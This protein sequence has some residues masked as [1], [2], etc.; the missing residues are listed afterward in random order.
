M[1]DLVASTELSYPAGDKCTLK[2]QGATIT[3]TGDAIRFRVECNH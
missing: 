1:P 3:N 2:T